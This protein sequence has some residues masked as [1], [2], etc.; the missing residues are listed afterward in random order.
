MDEDSEEYEEEN[1]S[2]IDDLI[3]FMVDDNEPA[4]SG[5]DR[6]NSTIMEDVEDLVV[7]GQRSADQPRTVSISSDDL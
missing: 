3:E 5:R 6:N 7:S 4:V 2:E 1:E